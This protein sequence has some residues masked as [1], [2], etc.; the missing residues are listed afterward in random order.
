M[1]ESLTVAWLIPAFP[2][3]GFLVLFLGRRQL[4]EPVSGWIATLMMAGSFVSGVAASGGRSPKPS[5]G[6]QATRPS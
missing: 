4:K 5:S 2:L 3:V 1:S 6:D